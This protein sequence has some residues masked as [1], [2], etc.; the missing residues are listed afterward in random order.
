M[1]DLKQEEK[2]ELFHAAEESFFES[3]FEVGCDE[4][5]MK[6]N[7]FNAIRIYYDKYEEAE[8]IC[9]LISDGEAFDEVT[10]MMK[11]Q[12][13][14]I[15]YKYAD[16]FRMELTGEHIVNPASIQLP[17]DRNEMAMMGNKFLGEYAESKNYD[18][19]ETGK[20][21]LHCAMSN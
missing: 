19:Y 6:E 9:V 16:R 3:N 12:E 11:I 14:I 10:A 13:L 2:E 17:S 4:E 21:L 7:Y 8:K 18:H 20:W 15:S 1:L 5:T